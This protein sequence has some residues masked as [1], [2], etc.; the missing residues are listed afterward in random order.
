MS[1]YV[2]LKIRSYYKSRE[3][4][5][6]FQKFSEPHSGQVEYR[7]DIPPGSFLPNG[8]KVSSQSRKIIQKKKIVQKVFFGQVEYNFDNTAGKFWSKCKILPLDFWK[9]FKITIFFCENTFL[10]TH[11][12]CSFDK[13]ADYF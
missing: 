6:Q 5:Q 12:E 13:P 7:F 9:Y 11:K 10:K 4:F 2:L 3:V 8:R 1:E